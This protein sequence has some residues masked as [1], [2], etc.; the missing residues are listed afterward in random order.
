VRGYF[1]MF[2]PLI[3]PQRATDPSPVPLRLVKAPVAGY[4]LPKAEGKDPI[5]CRSP[6]EMGRI[7]GVAAVFSGREG[8]AQRSLSL[9]GRTRRKRT[10]E[11]HRNDRKS[12]LRGKETPTGCGS[13]RTILGC[14]Q[15]DRVG[16]RHRKGDH[17]A[18]GVRS[19][20]GSKPRDNKR[21]A[22][23]NKP[24]GAG[25]REATNRF[26]RA[27]QGGRLLCRWRRRAKANGAQ[28]CTQ[29]LSLSR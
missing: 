16:S 21:A 12:L 5:P 7:G 26:P 6:R 14:C 20:S 3:P 2:A 29:F 10:Q 4:P 17:R 19:R 25:S 8:I 18:A 27:R 22:T 28:E 23:V 13:I 9:V 24:K 15:S 11:E 1:V